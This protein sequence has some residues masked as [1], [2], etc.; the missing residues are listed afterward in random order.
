MKVFD[1]LK[2]ALLMAAM[3]VLLV[4]LP[5]QAEGA[6]NLR[7]EGVTEGRVQA[8]Q[9][10]TFRA[11]GAKKGAA[12]ML[13]ITVDGNVANYPMNDNG[14]LS[15]ATGGMDSSWSMLP[16][17]LHYEVQAISYGCVGSGEEYS[18]T[19]VFDVDYPEPDYYKLEAYDSKQF[20][21]NYWA[22]QY[23]LS[24]VPVLYRKEGAKLD[25][26]TGM[27]EDNWVEYLSPLELGAVFRYEI[28]DAAGK[29]VSR[30]GLVKGCG[31]YTVK[32]YELFRDPLSG[33][34]V[35]VPAVPVETEIAD[36]SSIE[37][38]VDPD[39]LGELGD[40]MGDLKE[41]LGGLGDLFGGD[42]GGLIGGI[43][44]DVVNG[45]KEPEPEPEPVK[46]QEAQTPQTYQL[47]QVSQTTANAA[48]VAQAAQVATTVSAA[49]ES[50]A[51]P[52][53]QASQAAVAQPE[54]QPQEPEKVTTL[55]TKAND[56]AVVKFKAVEDA[57]GYEIVYGTTKGLKKNTKKVSTTKTRATLKKLSKKKTYYVKVRAYV[58]DENG[59]KV[60]GDYSATKKVKK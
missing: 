42:L 47:S 2:C 23:A 25:Q 4:A 13:R 9:Y 57:D 20:D 32:V 53:V 28:T 22:G 44:D 8:G 1:R 58:I 48:P 59:N 26:A 7:I 56:K 35:R 21:I 16:V 37:P 45:P 49:Q 41:D 46:S 52:T 14:Y 5:A 40:D 43:V 54:E 55:A 36:A 33:K 27:M 12:Y 50:Q 11:S 3:A 51:A 38:E 60:Y 29:V 39:K 10:L 18:D 34:T 6:L 19:Y 24:E 17:G 31:S 30:D 15:L